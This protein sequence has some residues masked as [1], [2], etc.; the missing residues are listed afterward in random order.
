MMT[1]TVWF[2]DWVMMAPFTNKTFWALKSKSK[3]L[4]KY[5]MENKKKNKADVSGICSCNFYEPNN[6]ENRTKIE[7]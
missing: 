3:W 5:K 6:L 1:I 7:E 2:M 4:K